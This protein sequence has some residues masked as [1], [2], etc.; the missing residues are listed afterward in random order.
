MI[1]YYGGSWNQGSAMFPLYDGERL[2][3]RGDTIVIAANYRLNVFGYLGS[4]SL[5]A[6][7]KST[8]NFGTQDQR[9]AMEWVQK[10]AAALRADTNSVMIFGESAG[11]GSVSNHLVLPRSFPY[12][13]R[14]A[15]ESGPF[16]DWIA[17]NLSIATRRF[18]I[19]V[20]HAGC[21]KSNSSGSSIAS[22]LRALNTT[23]IAKASHGLPSTGG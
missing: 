12:Y 2:S 21:A 8:G 13:T 16:A 1:F 7:D 15:M 19:M 10:N 23:D 6:D 4:D 3:S 17:Q 14:A 9:A 5:R 18:D 20:Q 11:A 22:C